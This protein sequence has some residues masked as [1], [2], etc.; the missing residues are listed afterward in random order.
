MLES[1]RTRCLGRLLRGLEE[2]A[3]KWKFMT[4]RD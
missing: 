2:R 1:L 3:E 4:F